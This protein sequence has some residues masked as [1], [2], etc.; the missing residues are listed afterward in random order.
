MKS[1]PIVAGPWQLISQDDSEHLVT[2]CHFSDWIEVDKLE[3]LST[4]VVIDK[5]KAHF[6]RYGIPN[7]CHM[8]N[9]PQFGCAEY[10]HF[11]KS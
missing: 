9:G 4:S 5:T 10:E 11:A 7:I 2:V 8:G 6:S 1:L 3:D